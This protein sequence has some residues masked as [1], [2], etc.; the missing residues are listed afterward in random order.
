MPSHMKG[1]NAN[2]SD[3]ADAQPLQDSILVLFK[4]KTIKLPVNDDAFVRQT[5]ANIS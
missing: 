4:T 2:Q 5:A 3:Q 1:L